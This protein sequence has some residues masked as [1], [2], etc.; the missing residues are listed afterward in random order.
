[1]KL[2]MLLVASAYSIFKSDGTVWASGNNLFGELGIGTSK[3]QTRVIRAKEVFLY[4]L[5]MQ[6]G[7]HLLKL[8]K[9]QQALSILFF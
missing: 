1:M 6:T 4:R 5:S 9:L 3:L 8:R 7:V 2:S